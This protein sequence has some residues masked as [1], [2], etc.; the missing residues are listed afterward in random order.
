MPLIGSPP[1]KTFQR[2][3]GT[4]SGST[5]WQQADAAGVGILSSAEDTHD[6]DVADALNG[7]WQ[8][9]GD[10]QPTADLP[11]NSYKFTGVGAA[12]ANSHFA[13]AAEVQKDSMKWGGT[14]GGSLTAYTVT[15]TPAVAAYSDGMEIAARAHATN[16][17]PVTLN[18]GGGA[19]AIKFQ[20]ADVASGSI[21]ANSVFAVRYNS[22]KS[23][24]D[25]MSPIPTSNFATTASV[26]LKANTTMIVAAGSVA[27]MRATANT[28]AKSF[29]IGDYMK[30]VKPVTVTDQTAVFIDYSAGINYNL[31]I[32]GNRFLRANNFA[33]QVGKTGRIMVTESGS[34]R[35]LN[36]ANTPYVTQSATDFTLG[37]GSGKVHVIYYE[38]LSAT[39]I[40]LSSV[41][42]IG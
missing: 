9:N 27:E 37:A 26:A 7:A 36:I 10:N 18:A 4:R 1:N 23:W 39:Q 31:T 13:R 20:A 33:A 17:S 30:A 6:Q 29:V 28:T 14:T 3:D 24:F 22:T 35:L 25:L 19:T 41:Q 38:I 34:A 16:G 2:T 21:T 32:A 42:S 11:L 15:L 12:T 8:R 40:L 5:T